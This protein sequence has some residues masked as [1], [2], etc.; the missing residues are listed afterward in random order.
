MPRTK[1][2]LFLLRLI[3]RCTFGSLQVKRLVGKE[4]GKE[5]HDFGAEG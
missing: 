3:D 5:K 2:P 4:L 1:L